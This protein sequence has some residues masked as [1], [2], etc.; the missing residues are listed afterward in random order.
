MLSQLDASTKLTVNRAEIVKL[1]TTAQIETERRFLEQLE[2]LRA[3][4][5]ALIKSEIGHILLTDKGL[6]PK[7]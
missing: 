3:E 2:K 4:T 7:E 5:L 1:V 6:E